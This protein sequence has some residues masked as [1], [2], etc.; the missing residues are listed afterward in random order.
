M[1]WCANQYKLKVLTYY[2]TTK[3]ISMEKKNAILDHSFDFALR[4]IEYC[5]ELE[6]KKKFVIA[7]QLLKSGTSIEANVRE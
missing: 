2:T 4:V 5:E 6:A 1:C 7:N 3:F